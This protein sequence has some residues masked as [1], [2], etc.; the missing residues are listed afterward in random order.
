VKNKEIF[1]SPYAVAIWWL[2][3]LFAVGN[4]I[5]LAVQG[6]DHLSVVA[7]AI[8]LLITGIV[9]VTAQRPRM[10]ADD[11]GLEIDNPL[12]TYR[13]GWPAVASVDATELVRVR[14]EWPGEQEEQGEPDKQMIY[15]WAVRSSRRKQLSTQMREQRRAN[16]GG[17]GVGLFGGGGYGGYA[18]AG[19]RAAPPP[20]PAIDADKVVTAL[21][22]RADE[23]R[24]APTKAKAEP[25]VT[26]WYWPG[27]A[28]IV[29]PALILLVAALV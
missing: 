18:T 10:V 24:N 22:A 15:S 7:G 8:L 25:P 27:V 11:D 14:C 20:A 2:W 17:R 6:R 16:T 21:N 4:L 29:I 23:V 26:T 9:Y 12:R 3:V 28:A 19:G 13:I 1:R 5:D